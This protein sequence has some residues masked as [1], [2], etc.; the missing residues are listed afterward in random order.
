MAASVAALESFHS[1]QL[2]IHVVAGNPAV[3]ILDFPEL[4]QQGRMFSR[5]LAL[6]ERQGGEREHVLTDTQLEGLMTASGKGF[7]TYAYGND[8]R[9]VDLAKF[10]TI[11][12]DEKIDL[13]NDEIGLRDFL[14]AKGVMERKFEFYTPVPPERVIISIPQSGGGSVAVR[15]KSGQAAITPQLR[16]AILHHEISHGEYYTNPAYSEYCRDFWARGLTES[17]RAAFRKFLAGKGYDP[18][19]GDLMINET[20]AYLIHTPSHDVFSPAMVG[21]TVGEV[22][23]L[24]SR[25]WAGAPPSRFF[26]KE[27]SRSP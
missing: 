20:Q 9:S 10:Y 27:R 17:E 26:Q 13:N 16:K 15:K 24:V 7:A 18:E 14:I 5:I 11:A 1:R 6:I 25:F 23:G 19:N 8:F 12:S 2:A 3:F 21:L 22:E 4:E